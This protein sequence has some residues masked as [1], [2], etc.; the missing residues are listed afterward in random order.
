MIDLSDYIED[1][2]MKSKI[3]NGKLLIYCPHTTA[4]ITINE[5]GDPDV[6]RD[7]LKTLNAVYPVR[8]DYKHFEG[9][10]H[11]HIKSS[12]MGVEKQLIVVNGSCL[13]GTRQSVYFCEFDGPRNRKIYI[14]VEAI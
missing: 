5:N 10:S 8:G 14:L 1:A 3:E 2:L 13:L 7:I 6:Q 4:G 11:A 12:L 9:N